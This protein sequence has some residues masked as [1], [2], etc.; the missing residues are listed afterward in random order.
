MKRPVNRGSHGLMAKAA[1]ALALLSAPVHAAPA[2]DVK[3]RVTGLREL[4]AAFK[5]VKDGLSGSPPQTVLIQQAAKQI[6]NA[7]RAQ[8]GWFPAG[9]G[10]QAGLKTAAR[11]DIW[12]QPQKFKAAQ[13][14][15][16]AAAD[17][18]LAKANASGDAAVLRAEMMKLG[19][20]CK[21][22]HDSFRAETH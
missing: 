11:P 12:N 13:D 18:F 1:L 7:A 20:A 6:R 5:T 21:S 2:D 14:G 22:C 3:V 4:G 10:P 8:Y 15:F 19:G 17:G 9:S 16:A